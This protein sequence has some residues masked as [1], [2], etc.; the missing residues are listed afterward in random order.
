M[1]RGDGYCSTATSDAAEAEENWTGQVPAHYGSE[2]LG[3][4]TR[5][6]RWE[7]RE[8][9]G[10]YPRTCAFELLHK[11]NSTG[12]YA[13]VTTRGRIEAGIKFSCG[14]RSRVIELVR[15]AD[16]LESHGH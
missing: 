4:S 1:H 13:C 3:V 11:N 14:G 6:Q 15:A 16:P 2:Y 8:D 12:Q 10:E 5:P 7:E 9:R